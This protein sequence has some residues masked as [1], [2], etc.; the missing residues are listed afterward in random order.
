[1]AMEN[2]RAHGVTVLTVGKE[3]LADDAC[4]IWYLMLRQIAG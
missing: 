4:G 2:S 3:T 1:M